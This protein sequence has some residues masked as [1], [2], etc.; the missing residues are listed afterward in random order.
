MPENKATIL[1]IHESHRTDAQDHLICE[2][3]DV[4]YD[5]PE[6]TGFLVIAWDETTEV[7]RWS[8]PN[9]S[10]DHAEYV[11]ETIAHWMDE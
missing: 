5:V 9:T 7:V 10:E 8:F 6:L 2:A 4:A 1:A 3:A 11:K